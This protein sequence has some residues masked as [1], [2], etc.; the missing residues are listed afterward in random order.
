MVAEGGSLIEF[1]EAI[2]GGGLG[3]EDEIENEYS[4]FNLKVRVTCIHEEGSG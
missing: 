2:R 3:Y 1:V 4:G